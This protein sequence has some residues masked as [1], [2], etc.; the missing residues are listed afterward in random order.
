MTLRVRWLG[1]VD[2]SDALAL[3]RALC[4]G[5]DDY[6]LLL[7]HPHT[8]TMGVRADAANILVDPHDVGARLVRADRGGDVTYHGPG[9]LVGYPILTLA[10]HAAGEM[11]STRAHVLNIEHL[12]IE[13]L[14]DLGLRH[15]SDERPGITRHRKDGGFFYR[16]ANGRRIVR[17]QAEAAKNIAESDKIADALAEK[18][19]IKVTEIATNTVGPSW[20]A[21]LTKD[22]ARALVVFFIVIAAYM[23]WQLEWRMAVSALLAVVHDVILTLGFYSVFGF[24]VTPATVIS[25]LT[26]LGFSLYDTIVVYDRVQENAARYD[27]TGRF[28][29]NAIMRRSLNQVLMRSLN[30]TFVAIL[31]VVAILV[32][33]GIVYGQATMLD[34]SLALLVGLVAG[35]YSSIAIASPLVVWLK[36]REPRY[37]KIRQRARDR[38]AEVE[39]DWIPVAEVAL[40]GSPVSSSPYVAFDGDSAPSTAPKVSP[41]AT[42]AAQYQREHPPRPRKQGKRR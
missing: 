15:V 23:S 8:Y 16:D 33:G 25:V 12:V 5:T 42:K 30:T 22:A 20:G 31:P 40:A 41:L 38:G 17:V 6:L 35:A 10:D 28:T 34:F 29:Y 26:I 32:I 36:E 13:A 1:R 27:R 18:A 21:S 39:A 4:A 19:G 3:Q 9:Q 14:A 7:E 11:P 37:A 2:Y 24:E